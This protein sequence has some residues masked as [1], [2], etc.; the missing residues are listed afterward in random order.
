MTNLAYD[1]I[2]FSATNSKFWPVGM[3]QWYTDSI[4]QHA[5]PENDFKYIITSSRIT[6]G[7]AQM[8]S[9]FEANVRDDRERPPY[10][11]A[12]RK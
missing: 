3:K 9:F 12:P 6:A 10:E 2:A 4:E 7:A 1:Q 11:G 8:W 5:N